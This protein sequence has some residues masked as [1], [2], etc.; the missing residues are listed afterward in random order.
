MQGQNTDCKCTSLLIYAY[1]TFIRG[2]LAS[3][4]HSISIRPVMRQPER[5]PSPQ[6]DMITAFIYPSPQNYTIH[7]TEWTLLL[8][9][10]AITA[11]SHSYL[12]NITARHW[13]GIILTLVLIHSLN[14]NSDGAFSMRM[15]NNCGYKSLS[16]KCNFYDVS[17]LWL[18]SDIYY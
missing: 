3:L 8:E 14:G 17:V 12:P 1:F 13:L 5:H 6:C 11:E 4:W 16:W 7:S 10:G 9:H 15:P 2:G 18:L